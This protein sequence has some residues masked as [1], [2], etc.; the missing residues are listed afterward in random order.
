MR[1]PSRVRSSIVT[2]L[3]GI[4]IPLTDASYLEAIMSPNR[5]SNDSSSWTTDVSLMFC[6]LQSNGIVNE[7][8]FRAG[9][10]SNPPIVS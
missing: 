2:T 1:P 7:T 4:W 3:S 6:T 10:Y 8:D 5:L 9:S